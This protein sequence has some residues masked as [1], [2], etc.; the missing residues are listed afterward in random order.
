LAEARKLIKKMYDIMCRVDKIPKNGWNNAQSYHY[1]KDEDIINALRDEFRKEKVVWLSRCKSIEVI[2]ALT[3]SGGNN[4]LTNTTMEY[5]LINVDDPEDKIVVEW[6]GQGTDSGDKGLY[7][8]FTGAGKTF[9]MK[10]FMISEGNDPE[11][12]EKVDRQ[13]NNKPASDGK[14]P[15][16]NKP[17]NKDVPKGPEATDAQKAFI[18]KLCGE[19]S[20]AVPVVNTKAEANSK[21]KELQARLGGK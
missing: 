18:K 2:T 3:K 7:K 17:S 21:I 14:P 9:L 16:N 5:T 11:A 8:A 6:S 1:H 13:D 10:T 15:S 20:L 4:F 19:L 12:D